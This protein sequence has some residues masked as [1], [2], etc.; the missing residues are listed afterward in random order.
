MSYFVVYLCRF[1]IFDFLISLHPARVNTNSCIQH[2]NLAESLEFVAR[3][4]VATT[5]DR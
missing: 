1:I 3:G 2:D 5:R 4:G